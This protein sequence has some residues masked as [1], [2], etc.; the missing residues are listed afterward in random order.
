MACYKGQNVGI[1]CD[2][3]T[4]VSFI[5]Q[6]LRRR[7]DLITLVYVRTLSHRFILDHSAIGK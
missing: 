5:R 1:H 6:R 2:M 7:L 3:D 4:D